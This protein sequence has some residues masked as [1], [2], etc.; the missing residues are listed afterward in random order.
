MSDVQDSQDSLEQELMALLEEATPVLEDITPILEEDTPTPVNKKHEAARDFKH[1]KI[2]HDFKK[3][4]AAPD[5]KEKQASRGKVL[6]ASYV[7]IDE[8]NH[9][10]PP[11]PAGPAPCVVHLDAAHT[12]IV[13]EEI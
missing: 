1:Q 2:A 8:I 3:E 11:R 10:A 5:F 9:A 6:L 13:D 7:T 12:N 4:E